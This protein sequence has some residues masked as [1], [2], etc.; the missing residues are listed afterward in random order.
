L[1]FKTNI[2]ADFLFSDMH[3]A[4]WKGNAGGCSNANPSLIDAYGDPEKLK[5]I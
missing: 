1:E 5:S 4:D 3:A 2:G